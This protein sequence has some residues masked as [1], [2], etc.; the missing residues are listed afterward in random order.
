VDHGKGDG[1]FI[2]TS[3]IGII[4]HNLRIAPSRVEPGDAIIINGD[5]G[6]HGI[7]IMAVREGLEF[8]ST[9]A[10]DCGPLHAQVAR[11]LKAGADIH[12]L[13]DLTR[14][15]LA[16]ALV[17]I[18]EVAHQHIHVDENAIEV[19]QDVQGACEILGFDPLYVA[20][21]GRFVTFL[22]EPQV[23]LALEAL[24][25]YTPDSEARLIGRVGGG[26]SGIVT[27]KTKIGV[28]R[29]VDMLSGEQL[30]RIC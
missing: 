8:E 3:G 7:A 6:R 14:G 13:R 30:P 25:G 23:G 18:A 21:E 20:N 10:S 15:G 17:E 5:I 24:R 11:L 19:R 4:E 29:I 1:A 28:S 26:R 27:L 16:T 22:P 2:N 12:C 9:I